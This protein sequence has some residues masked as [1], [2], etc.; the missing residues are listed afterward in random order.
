MKERELKKAKRLA[1]LFLVTAAMLFVLSAFFSTRRLVWL[2]ESDIRSGYG[3]C[4]G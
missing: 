4:F 2:A 1:M 3:W